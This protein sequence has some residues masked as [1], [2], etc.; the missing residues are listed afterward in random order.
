MYSGG[1]QAQVEKDQFGLVRITM[2]IQEKGFEYTVLPEETFV[3]PEVIL[4]Y[5]SEG[6]EKLTHNY[7]YFIRHN[8]CRG[9]YAL[10]E[11]PVV[12]NNWEATYFDFSRNCINKIAKE[13]SALGVDMIVLD[14]GWFGKRD[15]DNTSLGDWIV[16][17]EKIGGSLRALVD[18]INK[19]GL[20]FGLWIEPEMISEDSN[21]FRSNPEWALTI[22]GRKPILSR[23]QLV[24]DFSRKDVVDSIFNQ[25]CSVIDGVN[26]EYIKM[27]MN[28]SLSDVYSSVV[29]KE[30]QG[31]VYHNYV[32]GVYD[33]LQ[34]LTSRYPNILIEGC[35]GGGGRFD[36]GMLYYSP[37]IWTSDNTDAIDR[38]SIQ[39]GT[40][41]AFPLSSMGS[42]VSAVPNH[43]SGRYAPF[44]TRGVV[45]MAGCFGYEL[46]LC[47]LTEY[48]KE[49]VK[50]QII[51]YK[52][53]SKLIHEGRYY[54]LTNPI[55]DD[56]SSWMSVSEDG[57][58]ALLSAVF[59]KKI[60]NGGPIIIYLRGLQ[61]NA[62]YQ[63]LNKTYS[64]SCLMYGGYVLEDPIVEYDSFQIII[65][66]VAN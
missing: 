49:M 65:Q 48:E 38:L 24:L 10:S 40:S 35:S 30:R 50:Q 34:R 29:E 46:D 18:S 2:G 22:P 6:F 61:E 42:H 1:F 64:G 36:L 9:K 37:Q 45:A 54:R 17:E 8:I 63:I 20:K 14:D 13:A 5:S 7:H 56:V 27:D 62:T 39:Y 60:V 58:E 33:F 26:I 28:R 11:R 31:E 53:Y 66:R 19:M 25:I 16:N 21:L 15:C 23:N 57:E 51:D 44:N 41:F 12:I 55:A 52:K 47:D 3:A 59:M 32:L 43:Q 4:T